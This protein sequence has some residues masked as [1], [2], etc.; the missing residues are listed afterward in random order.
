MS[1]KVRDALIR[2]NSAKNDSDLH[3]SKNSLAYEYT[4]PNRNYNRFDTKTTGKGEIV[5]FRVH[6]TTAVEAVRTFVST[7]QNI[8]VPAGQNWALLTTSPAFSSLEISK[9][10]A[11]EVLKQITDVMF[12]I[13]RNSRFDTAIF[14]AFHDMAVSN[15]VLLIN[16]GDDDE[17]VKFM[18][19]DA[20]FVYPEEASNG[21][22]ESVYRDFNAVKIRNVKAIWPKAKLTDNLSKMLKDN[23][24]AE[25]DLIE[26]TIFDEETKLYSYMVLD[27]VNKDVLFEEESI[28][29]RWVV[30]RFNKM[31]GEVNGRGPVIDALPSILTVNVMKEFE[32]K[33]A[34][35][36]VTPPFMGF[37][38][39]VFNPFT[40][41]IRPNTV[42]PVNRFS[43]GQAPLQPL[44]TGQ[45]IQV[46]QIMINDEREQIR[47]LLFS[48]PLGPINAPS[49]TATE[50]AIRQENALEKIGPIPGR[51][52]TELLKKV[53]ERV[54]FIMANK[55][56]IRNPIQIGEEGVEITY[57]SPLSL[58]QGRSEINDLL[59]VH[60]ALA[61]IVGPEQAILGMKIQSLP[62]WIATRQGL[63]LSVV[64]DAEELEVIKQEAE[65]QIQ[66]QAGGEQNVA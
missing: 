46:S 18:S 8:L 23:I 34:A 61:S 9:A 59:Q 37:E 2:Y 26:A 63:D 3:W 62:E 21:V 49:R 39:G 53:V 11:D 12:D 52:Q 66:S 41:N 47:R 48:D 58:S 28:S 32:K 19:V 44:V 27:A 56:I 5:N 13:L 45:N 30:F 22:I 4:M 42:I 20:R 54:L 36:T 51:L 31:P 10:E 25:V 50:V 1:D 7:L 15:G 43:T 40:F 57:K 17:P 14:E 29:S 64:N 16:E 55:G 60:A 65:Q 35:L 6:D 38:D 33:G 24:D